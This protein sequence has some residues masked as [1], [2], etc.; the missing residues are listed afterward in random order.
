MGPP[1][2]LFSNAG[3]TAGTHGV[4]DVADVPIEVFEETWRVNCGSAYL[5]AQLCVPAME[6]AGWGRLVFC[7]SVA[8][9]TGGVVGPHYAYVMRLF[10]F[11]SFFSFLHIQSIPF[12]FDFE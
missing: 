3:S 6:R 7:S 2:I 4:E 10:F 5:L 9:F 8:A 11:F 12:R 1:T